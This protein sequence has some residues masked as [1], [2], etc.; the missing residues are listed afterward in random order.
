MRFL[1]K[2]SER[3]YAQ[4]I[5]QEPAPRTQTSRAVLGLALLLLAPPGSLAAALAR[6][7]V[8]TTP[9]FAFYS[10][11]E[12]NLNDALINAGVA[13]KFH[14]SELFHAGEEVACF[15]RLPSAV[16][17]AWNRALDYYAE[18]VSPGGWTDRGQY[19][20]RMQLA[21]FDDEREDAADRQ[22]V[23]IAKSFRAAAAPAYRECRWAAQDEKNRRWVAA[24]QPRLSAHER[25]I[26][27]RLEQLYRKPWGELPIPVDVVETVDWSGAN[28]ILRDPNG[29]HVLVSTD[30]QGPEAL[31]V[32]FHE[33]SHLFM[34][35]ND[36]LQQAIESAAG[37]V[38]WPLPRDLWHVVLFY[39]T[40]EA[41]RRILDES[42]ER[43]YRPMVYGI[44]DRGTWVEFREPIDTAWRPY[45]DGKRTL[46][47][48]AASLID[49]LRKR[50]P[51]AGRAVGPLG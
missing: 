10:D 24:L 36:P 28:T 45:V 33:A 43:G 27:A 40:G 22:L 39:T 19:L 38:H 12:T 46:A 23:D 35:H 7:P 16:R 3:I 5:H 37:A 31:E 26:A 44:Y 6:T 14:R 34:R 29:G 9:H 50:A 13:R 47:E 41:V 2:H 20:I 4:I 49:T 8:A 17:A 15:E 30:N 21:G 11:F 51:L 18:I 1:G 42:G 25:T 48:A 32:V